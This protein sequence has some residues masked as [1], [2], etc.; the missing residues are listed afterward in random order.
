VDKIWPLH[1]C[2][3]AH[4]YLEKSKHFGKVVLTID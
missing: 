1:E 3:T 4:N 2:A